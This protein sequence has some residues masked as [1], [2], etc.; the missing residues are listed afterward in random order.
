[1]GAVGPLSSIESFN[2]GDMQ[3]LPS[4][5][6]PPRVD[7]EGVNSYPAA[8]VVEVVARGGVGGGND[9]FSLPKV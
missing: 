7:C 4:I 2:I 5:Q 6:C 1:M 8:I 3:M 9:A